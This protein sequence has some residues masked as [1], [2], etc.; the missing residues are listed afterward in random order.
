MTSLGRAA[1]MLV[2]WVAAR[3]GWLDDRLRF[4]DLR[5]NRTAG[6]LNGASARHT[7]AAV[8]LPAALVFFLINGPALRPSWRL[9]AAG[10]GFALALPLFSRLLRLLVARQRSVEWDLVGQSAVLFAVAAAVWLLANDAGERSATLL[11]RHVLLVVVVLIALAALAGG[12]L[13]TGLFRSTRGRQTVPVRLTKVELFVSRPAPSPVTGSM[14]LLAAL[15]AITSS[16]GRVLFPPTLLV[17]FV[18]REWV[19]W[20][21][22]AALVVNVVLLA[23]AN[24]DP[25]FSASWNLLHRLFFGGWAALVSLFVIVLGVLRLVDVQYVSTL[26]DGARNYTIAGYIL[27]AYTAAW[28]HDYWVSTGAAIRA[29]DLLGGRGGA[30]DASIPYAIDPLSATTSVAADG[31]V[32]Q[33]HGAGRLL[34]LRAGG[35]IPYFHAYTPTDLMEALGAGLSPKD[36]CRVDVNWIKWR[37]DSHFLLA[38]AIVVLLFVGAGLSLRQLPQQPL[39]PATAGSGDNASPA[40]APVTLLADACATNTPVVAVAASGGGTRAALYTASILERLERIGR[41]QSVRLVSGV[42]G[43]GAALAYFASHRSALSG[44]NSGEWQ[45]Y[46]DAMQQPYIEDV[47]DGSGEWRI[48]AGTRLGHLLAESFSRHWGDGRGTLGEI[49]DV[50]LLLN[51]AIAGRFVRTAQDPANADLAV[52][53]RES[54]RPGLNDVVGGRVVFTNLDVPDHLGNPVLIEGEPL[55][56][57]NDTRLPIFVI[58]APHVRLV[59][60]AAAN[61]NFP[62]VFSNAPV[63]RTDMRL[64]ITDGGAVDNRG[65]E[66]LLMT[67]RYTLRSRGEQCATLPPLHIVEIEASAFS[68][69]YRQDRGIGSLMAAGTALASQLDG[70]LLDDIRRLYASSGQDPARFVRFHYLP[71]PALLRRSG[72]FGTHWMLQERVNVCRDPDCDDSIVLTGED[73]VAVL[74]SLGPAVAGEVVAARRIPPPAAAIGPAA[75]EALDLI[76]REDV[77][78]EPHWTRLSNCLGASRGSC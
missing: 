72:S 26:L 46:F 71:M 60:A 75:A 27:F 2:N 33:S 74:R 35:A 44:G 56:P 21:F 39:I 34:V 61:A 38:A 13:A 31:R 28:W 42:S 45:R 77:E 65:L 16:P 49:D 30:I 5:L 17:V 24:L 47:L 53:E 51:S 40:L 1:D 36:P 37:F 12:A 14:L 32:I 3:V 41:L 58:N 55:R 54:G 63:D 10:A 11:Y 20:I 64:W 6:G 62:P 66:T 29:L 18:E 7:V 67:L 43:G 22:Y 15:G 70:E 50:G 8:V 9:L 69:G 68:D 73:V 23:F 19:A 25:R 52:L 59:D 48:A 4:L 76:R 78:L 57:R